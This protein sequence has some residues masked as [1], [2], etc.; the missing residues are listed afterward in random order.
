[1]KRLQKHG[2]PSVGVSVL[3]ACFLVLFAMLPVTGQSLEERASALAWEVLEP[4]VIDGNLSEWNTSTPLVLESETQLI[5]DGDYWGGPDD[6]SAKVYLMWDEANL[7]IGAEVTEDTPFGAIAMLPIDDNDNFALYVSTNPEADPERKAYES[8]DFR[9]ILVTDNLFFDTAIDRSMVSDL[10]GFWSKGMEGSSD[11]LKGYERAAQPTEVGYVLEAKVPWS[12]FS[13]KKIP[14]FV[15]GV[16][17]S[18]GFDLVITDIAY[19]CPGTEVIPQLAWT[20]DETLVANPSAW[21]TLRFE[22][23]A[24]D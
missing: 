2:R 23:T 7:Y 11:V 18:I 15:P 10:Q 20:G 13:N 14:L 12:N 21:G 6:L 5:R 4:I 17:V 1:M 8:T 19:P 24:A 22:S 3:A 9:V 16:G